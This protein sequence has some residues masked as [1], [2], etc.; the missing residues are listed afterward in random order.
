[1]TEIH[2]LSAWVCVCHTFQHRGVF[3]L[4]GVGSDA[5]QPD[6][7]P[8]TGLEAHEVVLLEAG[9]AHSLILTADEHMSLG[10]L[11]LL[12]RLLLSTLRCVM[13]RWALL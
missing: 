5:I 9:G 8:V 7:L 12:S 10:T 13:Q 2:V 1:M 6:P 11:L 4:M 3:F